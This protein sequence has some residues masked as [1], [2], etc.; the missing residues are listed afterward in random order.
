MDIPHDLHQALISQDGKYKLTT[1]LHDEIGKETITFRKP[2]EIELAV[3][4]VNV[5]EYIENY[6]E[7]S[8]N[9]AGYYYP[10]E[11][12]D[13]L[14]EFPRY[15]AFGVLVWVPS[16]SEF[17]TYDE[18]HCVLRSFPNATFSN[19]IDNPKRFFNCMWYPDDFENHLVRPWSDDRFTN[20]VPTKEPKW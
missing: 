10:I 7:P 15:R 9:L 18:D 4:Y 1:I 12:Y 13:L 17:A 16:V 6:Q 5:D 14:S 20:I 19:I 11:A 2:D 8:T 3:L